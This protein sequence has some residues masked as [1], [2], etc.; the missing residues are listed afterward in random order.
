MR[1]FLLQ[2]EVQPLLAFTSKVEKF[3]IPVSEHAIVLAETM[4]VFA[5]SVGRCVPFVCVLVGFHIT[6]SID[7]CIP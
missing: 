3:F 1:L 2:G 5:P 4:K 6:I 7:G